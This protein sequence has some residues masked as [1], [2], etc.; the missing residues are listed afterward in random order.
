MRR[1]TLALALAALAT[2]VSASCGKST[3]PG[4][5]DDLDAAL[6][7]AQRGGK[8]V[9]A[10]FSGSDWCGY[11]KKLESEVLSQG[12]FVARLTNEF[13]LVFIDSPR[14]K[15][16]L[17]EKAVVENPKLTRQFGVRGFPTVLILSATGEKL[18]SMGY[19]PGGAKGYAE[20]VLSVRELL[21]IEA[22]ENGSAERIRRIHEFLRDRGTF[23]QVRNRRL[24]NEILA[25][26]PEGKL[27]YRDAYAFFTAVEPTD[28]RIS[29]VLQTFEEDCARI[30]AQHPG[31]EA[32][33]ET[34][35]KAKLHPQVVAEF[36]R[37]S[38]AL[39]GAKVPAHV[40]SDKRK[41][42]AAL[43]DLI[44]RFGK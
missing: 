35:I 44:V 8:L 36:R 21:A 15:S 10:V 43:D 20:Q 39:S 22:L 24:V 18:R 4:F 40:E 23:F 26:D 42:L 32:A 14:D 2:S 37:M 41:V 33:A 31:D 3:P 34:E 19:L 9:F 13:A 17:S 27:G 30:R 11:C 6:A 7:E 38:A 1:F 16:L 29:E 28:N 25:A 12:E 5:T